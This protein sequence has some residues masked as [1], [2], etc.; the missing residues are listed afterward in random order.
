MHEFGGPHHPTPGH[1][2]Q[3]LVAEADPQD[4]QARAQLADHL[5]ADP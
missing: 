4:R 2:G 5:E 3:A 1:L